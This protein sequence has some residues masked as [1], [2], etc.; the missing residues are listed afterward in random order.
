[1]FS[2][3]QIKDTESHFIIDPFTR[4]ITNESAA[5]N[6]IVQYDHNSERF[7]FE[8]P[9]YVDGHDMY[10][11]TEVRIHYCNTTSNGAWQTNGVYIPDDVALS[12]ESEDTVTFSWLLS[13]A[14][15][16][17]IGFLYFSIQFV[18]LNGETIEYAWNTGI[19]KDIVIIESINN[20]EG[21][22]V[23]NTD[24]LGA[25]KADLDK[26]VARTE[27]LL[28]E[29]IGDVDEIIGDGT[30]S[31]SG[32]I[33]EVEQRLVDLENAVADLNY[34]GI[35]IASFSASPSTAEIGNTVKSVSLS[36]S[37]NKT[38]K[39]LTLD[40]SA[41]AVV[42]TA[43][44]VTGT[45]TANKTWTLKATDERDATA[46]KTAKLSFVN[47]VYY[48]V[49]AEPAECNSAFVLG[50]KKEL[51]SS[52]LTSFSVNAASGQY[53]FYCLPK[54]RDG[55]GACSFRAGLME[56]GFMLYATISFTNAYG[57]TEPYYVYRSDNAGLGQTS[58]T[59]S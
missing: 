54:D 5:N 48:G 21:I 57:Y 40:G 12:G 43:K 25:W 26:A 19:Y 11:G 36:W 28:E 4:F 50:L 56:G 16:Q 51:R 7:T 52:K 53:I 20:A 18:C 30:G 32:T 9:R 10:D 1:M 59:V 6:T 22:S 39:A 2:I 29:Y 33:S 31:G 23:E 13:S 34:K 3:D 55:M 38:P 45:F 37:T 42:D 27:E 8:I 14:N 35:T 24:V 46:T 17:Y 15:T 58:V 44:T 41:L 49:A 47:G